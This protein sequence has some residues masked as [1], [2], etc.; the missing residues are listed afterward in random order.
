MLARLAGGSKNITADLNLAELAGQADAYD[1]F[2]KQNYWN[3]TLQTYAVLNEN[4]PFTSV[5]IRE[6]LLWVASDAYRNLVNVVSHCPNCGNT[7]EPDWLY[8][9]HCGH[10]L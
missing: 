2:C 4:H 10:K 5:R 1:A 3:T 8:C 9:Q 7:I 6:M